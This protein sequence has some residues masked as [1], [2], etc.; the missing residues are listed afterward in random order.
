M[1]DEVPGFAVGDGF[2][3]LVGADAVP[4]A[5]GCRERLAVLVVEPGEGDYFSSTSWLSWKISKYLLAMSII[6]GVGCARNFSASSFPA[7]FSM[8]RVNWSTLA[9]SPSLISLT[10]SRLMLSGR[11]MMVPSGKRP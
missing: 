11:L 10:S 8:R 1:V 9:T 5:E 6:E 4:F 3:D 2:A 7:I